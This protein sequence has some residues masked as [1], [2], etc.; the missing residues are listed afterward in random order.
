MSRE[1]R[2]QRD[3]EQM[4]RTRR[5]SEPETSS[6]TA[7]SSKKGLNQAIVAEEKSAIFSCQHTL[8]T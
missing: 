8:I 7:S 3:L 2:Q 4:A 6:S 1:E 5:I